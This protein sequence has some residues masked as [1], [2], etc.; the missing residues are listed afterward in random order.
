M[1]TPFNIIVITIRLI[2]FLACYVEECRAVHFSISPPPKNP[3]KCSMHFYEP[4]LS[5]ILLNKTQCN[6][7]S[8]EPPS[9]AYI[10]HFL[11]VLPPLP[12]SNPHSQFGN[13]GNM[14]TAA[15][16]APAQGTMAF[17]PHPSMVNVALPSP[18]PA[19]H[20]NE[21]ED[22]DEDYDS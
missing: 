10:I 5:F 9:G 14:A 4:S 1:P 18:A 8:L 21:E 2:R 11:L 17:A 22:D 7:K 12:S 15:N 6:I 13:T 19:P 20:K 16:P 3:E